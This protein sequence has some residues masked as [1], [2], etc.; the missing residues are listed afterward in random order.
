MST[1]L[2]AAAVYNVDALVRW[3]QPSVSDPER[4]S[5][6][7]DF[8]QDAERISLE[9]RFRSTDRL[10]RYSVKF[11]AV[12]KEKLSHHL[13][14]IRDAVNKLDVSDGKKERL[15]R[16]IADL[17]LELNT[18]RT[19]MAAYGALVSEIASTTEVAAQPLISIVAKVGAIFGLAAEKD[20]PRLPSPE[21]PKQIE[22]KPHPQKNLK[23]RRSSPDPF[24][25][26]NP[27]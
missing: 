15:H 8:Q 22:A 4:A 17:E 27:F 24:E 19:K 20:Q 7:G 3:N 9:L 18:D 13:Q 25:D 5:I 1:V 2:A 12:A 23:N 21:K 16:R 14:Q 10:K 11:D 26:E 6:Y